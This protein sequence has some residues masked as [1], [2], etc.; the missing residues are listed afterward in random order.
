M[1]K[2]KVLAI[3]FVAISTVY[4]TLGSD[5]EEDGFRSLKEVENDGSSD[6][7]ENDL[8]DSEG[9]NNDEEAKDEDLRTFHN[10]G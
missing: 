1:W 10:E 9:I 6:E 2:I 3:F 7:S 8:N 4:A 5:L